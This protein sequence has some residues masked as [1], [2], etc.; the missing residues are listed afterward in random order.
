MQLLWQPVATMGTLQGIRHP[1][2]NANGVIAPAPKY[3]ISG[4]TPFMDRECLSHS[5]PITAGFDVGS[6]PGVSAPLLHRYE[7]LH[8]QNLLSLPG[9][10]RVEYLHYPCTQEA[11]TTRRTLGFLVT[12][13]LG[14][15]AAPRGRGAT[16]VRPVLGCALVCGPAPPSAPPAG[17]P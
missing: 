1:S 12:L 11:P 9:L 8:R 17:P 2:Q 13:I 15:L 3:W 14:L 5:V 6:P 4:P 7:R 16:P 10:S